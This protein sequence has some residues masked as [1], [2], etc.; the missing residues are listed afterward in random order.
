MT[1]AINKLNVHGLSN[2]VTAKEDH[3]NMVLATELPGSSNK[4]ERFSYKGEW[5]N[6]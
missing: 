2:R 5:A 1:L 3:G 4:S 6:L